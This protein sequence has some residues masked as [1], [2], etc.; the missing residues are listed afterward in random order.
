M[1]DEHY[2][3]AVRSLKGPNVNERECERTAEPTRFG[4]E[5]TPCA[6]QEPRPDNALDS[7]HGDRRH[8]GGGARCVLKD[9]AQP[10][11]P[12]LRGGGSLEHY[13]TSR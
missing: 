1:R 12:K 4:P 9:I 10:S 3:I 11:E 8:L 6:R 2:G 5:L 7:W 13:D